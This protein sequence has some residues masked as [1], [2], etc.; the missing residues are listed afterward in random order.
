MNKLTLLAIVAVAAP[1]AN[2][3]IIYD[4]LDFEYTNGHGNTLGGESIF[5]TTLDQ[6]VADNF[7]LTERTTITTV[8]LKNVCFGQMP[9]AHAYLRWFWDSANHTNPGD[10]I[11][12]FDGDL[13]PV[14]EIPFDDTTFSLVG[15]YVRAEGLSYTFD[16]GVYWVGLQVATQDWH[17]TLDGFYGMGGEENQRKGPRDRGGD[18]GSTDW[19]QMS[20]DS[21]MRIEGEVVPEPMTVLALGS[22]LIA[23]TARRRR[24]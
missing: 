13:V 3:A 23:L 5:G 14:T 2:A 16:P 10:P 22:A 21:N 12:G 18:W 8:T 11:N 19:F 20:W 6:Q 15:K 7:T 1:T 17:F 9:A 4:T 24:K